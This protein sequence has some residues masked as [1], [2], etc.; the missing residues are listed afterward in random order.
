[1]E[2]TLARYS[3]SKDV[4]GSVLKCETVLGT[5]DATPKSPPTRRV[6]PRG[7]PRV[8]A[9]L[10]LSPFSLPDRDR[11]VD[12]PAL[13]GSWLGDYFEE[14]M[15]P[16]AGV[17]NAQGQEGCQGPSRP[18]GRNRG[19]PLRRR[20]GHEPSSLLPPHSIPLGRPSAPAPSIQ[21]RASNLDWHLIS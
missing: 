2:C 18:S 19:L 12:S 11:R 14:M 1:M 5:L 3:V 15:F 16:R 17:L 13:S 7:T 20:R 10:P 21:Y 4:P 8:P 9:P 6:P